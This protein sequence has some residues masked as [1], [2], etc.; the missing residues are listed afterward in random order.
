MS[1]EVAGAAVVEF[2]TWNVCRARLPQVLKGLPRRPTILMLQEVMPL[3]NIDVVTLNGYMVFFEKRDDLKVRAA[4]VVRMGPRMDIGRVETHK[5]YTMVEVKAADCEL[6]TVVSLYI[7]HGRRRGDDTAPVE[8]WA[9]QT[10]A[11]GM[12]VV[13]DDLNWAGTYEMQQDINIHITNSDLKGE[14]WREGSSDVILV[15]GKSSEEFTAMCAMSSRTVAKCGLG[16]REEKLALWSVVGCQPVRVGASR[17]RPQ[18]SLV[19]LDVSL[20]RDRLGP[21]Q[22][23]IAAA[24]ARFCAG[25]AHLLTEAV[26]PALRFAKLRVEI[27]PVLN[28]DAR[29]GACAL[30]RSTKSMLLSDSSID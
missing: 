18:A 19:F 10:S 1:S 20:T 9:K 24:W 11:S 26:S 6:I 2:A 14:R 3:K 30:S 8:E 5:L 16:L 7:P 12:T 21:A 27:L 23:R 15:V 4:V 25:T 29:A 28:W 13:A 22:H 17:M